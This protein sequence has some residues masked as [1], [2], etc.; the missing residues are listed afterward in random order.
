MCWVGY[1]YYNTRNTFV[2]YLDIFVKLMSKET[3]NPGVLR[4]IVDWRKSP[5]LWVKE[6]I[7]WPRGQFLSP[8][9]LDALHNFNKEKRISI[10]SG[11]GCGK[12]C[13]A[14]ILSLYFMSTRA[15]P[16]VVVT[17][18]TNRQLKDIYWS[19]LAKWFRRSKLQDEFVQ[20]NEIF[21]HKDYPK[22]WWIRTV[23][24]Q[25]RA[26]KDEQAETLAGFHGEHLLIIG[27]EASGI[28]DPVFIPLEGAM[29][30]EDNKCLLIG[31]MTKNTGYFYDTH[32]N[33]KISKNWK[34]FHWDS[35]KSPLVSKETIEFFRNKYGEDSSVFA[36]R[37]AGNP[38]R[39]DET[40]LIPLS[41]AQQCVGN[42]I[43]VA[44]D[45]PKYLGVDVARY[46]DDKSVILPRRG[47]KI[48]PWEMFKGLNTIDL[49]GHINQTYQ[50]LGADGVA[51]DE[52]GVGAGVTDWLMKH[53][54]VTCY[55]INVARTSSDIT[56]YNRLRDELWCSVRDKCMR[57]MY[58]FPDTEEGQELC[59]E[60][61][62]PRYTFN[63]Q[64]GIRVESKRDMKLRGI[65]SP[66]IADALCLTEYFANTAF[67]VWK[68]KGTYQGRSWQHNIDYYGLDNWMIA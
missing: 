68:K 3:L 21:F 28:R 8:Q 26:T 23:S 48:Y 15:F 32:F 35:R 59:N 34:C 36:V 9:Q 53:K 17:A 41:W 57:G 7:E 50:E 54:L 30:Q 45:E 14:A 42:E 44:E 58:S 67:R 56:K 20:Q 63:T 37:I 61:A 65:M 25:A 33:P 49:G 55:G 64:G 51:V 16:K 29:T 66:N 52:I 6:C 12:D 39:E 22:E 5:V 47:L 24:P 46:G 2:K 62:A 40:T 43:E 4:H 31:N 11:H 27:D 1:K 13:I 19:E 10:R 60:L 18:P 38:P